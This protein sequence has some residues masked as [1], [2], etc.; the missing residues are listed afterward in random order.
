MELGF[1]ELQIYTMRHV[2]EHGAQL[3]MLLGRNGV[4]GPDWIAQ[5]RDKV[6]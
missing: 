1:L 4:T 5:A 3:N 6:S 2:Q